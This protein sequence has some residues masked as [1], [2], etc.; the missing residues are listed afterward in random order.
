MRIDHGGLP[1]AVAKPFLDG[2]NVLAAL[3]SVSCKGV[4]KG[5]AAGRLVD[6]SPQDDPLHR[7]LD[8]GRVHVVPAFRSGPG[9]TP[10]VRLWEDPLPPPFRGRIR[11]RP[12]QGHR[13]HHP[14]QPAARSAW[15]LCRCGRSVAGLGDPNP[16]PGAGALPSA[17][18][19]CAHISPQHLPMEKEQGG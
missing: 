12:S 6:S 9:V 15:C 16:G 10:T 17:A 3:Q 8:H 14:P 5:V 4:A 19:R 18:D 2:A 1:I 11:V 13:Q 7:P